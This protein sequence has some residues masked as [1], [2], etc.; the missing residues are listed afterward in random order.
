M[1]RNDVTIKDSQDKL[2]NNFQQHSAVK[3]CAGLTAV[4]AKGIT[5]SI[6]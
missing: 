1:L 2:K 4:L 6:K 5:T 3:E